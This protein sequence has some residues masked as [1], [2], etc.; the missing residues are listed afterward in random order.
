M[1]L[2]SYEN[3]TSIGITIKPYYFEQHDARL[4]AK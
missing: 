3:R 4:A 1:N 2:E